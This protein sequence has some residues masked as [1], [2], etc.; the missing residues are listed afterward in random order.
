MLLDVSILMFD[1]I[2]ACKK[3]IYFSK[4]SLNFIFLTDSLCKQFQKMHCI[5]SFI[6]FSPL[7]EMYFLQIKVKISNIATAFEIASA[8]G[9]NPIKLTK[10]DF[11]HI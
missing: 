10:V 8:F 3:C 1:N 6:T 4:K 7:A 2:L 5:A 11:S 9:Q